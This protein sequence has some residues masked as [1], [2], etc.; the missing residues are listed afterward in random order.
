[1]FQLLIYPMID[2]RRSRIRACRSPIP[3]VWHREANIAGWAAHLGELGGSDAMPGYAAPARAEDLSGL[4]PAFIAGGEFDLFLDE[5]LEYAK[6]LMHG[7]VPVELHV[8]PGAFHGS[9]VFVP[10]AEVSQ[11]W[12]RDRHDALRRALA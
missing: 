10:M 4:P 1:M 8:H 9:D 5:D 12:A 11:R 2:H 6:R 7:G 3:Q